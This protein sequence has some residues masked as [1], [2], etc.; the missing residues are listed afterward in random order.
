MLTEKKNEMPCQPTRAKESLQ[1]ELSQR[2]ENDS[3]ELP[4]I[5]LDY[6]HRPKSDLRATAFDRWF[7]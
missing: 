2:W 7:E 1:T 4:G 3:R 5:H 6:P